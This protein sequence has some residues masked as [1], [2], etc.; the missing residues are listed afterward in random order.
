MAAAATNQWH[1]YLVG[2]ACAVGWFAVFFILNLISPRLLGFGD[3]RFSL[4][5]GISLGWLGIGYVFLGF[6]T[7]NLIGAVIGLTLIATKRMK[8]TDR[9]PYGVFLAL[10]CALAVFAGPE[11]LRPFANHSF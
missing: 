2:I 5:L 10:G 6:F 1:A 9:I 11:L 3:V 8:R 7:A 4:V